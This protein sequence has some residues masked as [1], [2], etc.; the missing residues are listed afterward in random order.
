MFKLWAI[1]IITVE[2]NLAKQFLMFNFPVSAS[3]KYFRVVWQ[4]M[5]FWRS[6]ILIP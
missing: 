3:N 6:L 5:L 1:V 4:L 2:N